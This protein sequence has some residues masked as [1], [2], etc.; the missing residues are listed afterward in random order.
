MTLSIRSVT[1]DDWLVWERMR[2]ALWPGEDERHGEEISRF[3]AG[4]P[5]D[6]QHVLFAEDQSEVIAFA[7]LSIRT[8]LPGLTTERVGYI[9]GLYVAPEVRHRGVAQALL[10]TSRQWS[11]QQGCTRFASDRED[12]I[13]VDR[14]FTPSEDRTSAELSS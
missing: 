2:Y 14:K 6:M 12:R 8:D 1:P 7:E 10:A 4:D 13:I 11:Q 5:V 3:F 9:E